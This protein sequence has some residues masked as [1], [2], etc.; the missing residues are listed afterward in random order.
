MYDQDEEY[1]K[2]NVHVYIDIS[3]RVLNTV[4]MLMQLRM[5]NT[6]TFND[7][8]VTARIRSER[9]RRRVAA[10]QLLLSCRGNRAAS[11]R[12]LRSLA[13]SE[14][15]ASIVCWSL[16]RCAAWSRRLRCRFSTSDSTARSSW[17]NDFFASEM[18][19]CGQRARK[20]RAYCM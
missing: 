13:S 6:L 11:S 3:P 7:L 9:Q 12:V 10:A 4:H 1:Q 5:Y 20:A 14:S 15:A 2:A 8:R 19:L 16:S 17:T 18:R